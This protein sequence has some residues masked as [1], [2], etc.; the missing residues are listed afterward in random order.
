M[1]LKLSEVETDTTV[2][3]ETEPCSACTGT[4]ECM[5]YRYTWHVII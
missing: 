2:D 1:L 3:M 5:A 4:L